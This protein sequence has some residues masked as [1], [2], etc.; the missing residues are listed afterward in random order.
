MLEGS[1]SIEHGTA[2]LRRTPEGPSQR[3]SDQ[4]QT[5]FTLDWE[6]LETES[7]SK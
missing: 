4:P 5:W 2:E 6:A 7:V 1:V 3:V